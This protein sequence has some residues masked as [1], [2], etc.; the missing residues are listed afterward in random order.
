M[1]QIK[2]HLMTPGLNLCQVQ[3]LGT[4]QGSPSAFLSDTDT[5]SKGDLELGIL[6]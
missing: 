6:A 5:Y 1:Y 2:M 4:T 3:I